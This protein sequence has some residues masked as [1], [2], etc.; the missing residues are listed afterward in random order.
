MT[1]SVGSFKILKFNCPDG[2]NDV[3]SIA[4]EYPNNPG[5]KDLLNFSYG[6]TL[7]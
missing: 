6:T 3:G 4:N 2:C 1:F 7:L 5:S